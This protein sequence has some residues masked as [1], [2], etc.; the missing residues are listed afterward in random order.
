MAG[1][2]QIPWGGGDGVVVGSDSNAYR[3]TR[4]SGLIEAGSLSG[5]VFTPTK[6]YFLQAPDSQ[7]ISGFGTDG[8]S[9]SGNADGSAPGCGCA[10]SVNDSYASAG[11]SGAANTVTIYT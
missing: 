9:R 7:A 3:V 2:V 10:T 6:S 11:G 5:G 4:A 1:P 8:S